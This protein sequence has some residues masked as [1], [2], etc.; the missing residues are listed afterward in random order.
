MILG[1]VIGEWMENGRMDG[2]MDGW[3]L[4]WDFALRRRIGWHFALFAEPPRTTIS[5]WLPT[6][7]KNSL[8]CAKGTYTL[9]LS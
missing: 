7:M 5:I 4:C 9:K 2:W 3:A 8:C 1:S 6:T